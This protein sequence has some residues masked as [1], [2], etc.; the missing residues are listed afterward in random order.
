[1]NDPPEDH[2]VLLNEDEEIAE[3]NRDESDNSGFV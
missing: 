2:V 1:L 3:T